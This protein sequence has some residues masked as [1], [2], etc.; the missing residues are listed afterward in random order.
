MYLWYI[1]SLGHK[2]FSVNPIYWV[3]RKCT[4]QSFQERSKYTFA[5]YTI[6][7]SDSLQNFLSCY[8]V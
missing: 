7:Q 3:A 4:Y 2:L 1:I 8:V 6:S 5:R